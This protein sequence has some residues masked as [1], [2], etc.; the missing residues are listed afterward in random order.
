MLKTSTPGMRINLNPQRHGKCPWRTHNMLPEL[1][2]LVFRTKMEKPQETASG[3]MGIT[4]GEEWGGEEKEISGTV[5]NILLTMP[6]IDIIR[7]TPSHATRRVGCRTEPI[8]RKRSALTRCRQSCLPKI[9]SI[10][11]LRTT[12]YYAPMSLKETHTQELGR[13]EEK[14]KR[15][16]THRWFLICTSVFIAACRRT[17]HGLEH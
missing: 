9:A 16:R 8:Q 13:K 2:K 6:A 7:N 5:S 11:H 10:R 14:K 3:L 17:K 4:T 12:F 1:S 15:L